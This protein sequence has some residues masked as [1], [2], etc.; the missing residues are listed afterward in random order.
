VEDSVDAAHHFKRL[1][2]LDE[3]LASRTIA[4]YE[5]EYFMLAF[6]SFR[7][8]VGTRKRRW[9]FSWDGK[10]GFATISNPYEPSDGRA[11]PPVSGKA[12]GLGLGNLDAPF[13]FLKT[14]DFGR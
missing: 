10:E 14:F 9:G 1:V 8:E 13:E 2:D 7:L 5:H 12:I 3:I 4:I 6:G 11:A